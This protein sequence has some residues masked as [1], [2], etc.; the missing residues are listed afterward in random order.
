MFAALN[1]YDDITNYLTLRCKNLNIEAKDGRTI[2]IIYLLNK[3]MGFV[4]KILSRGA[5]INFQNRFG[6]TALHYAVED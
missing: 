5:D 2:L 1:G 4:R 6:L 3:R